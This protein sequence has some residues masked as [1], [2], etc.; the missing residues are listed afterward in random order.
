MNDALYRL[1][2]WTVCWRANHVCLL[3]SFGQSLEVMLI[4]R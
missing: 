1:S 3:C 4:W 2:N